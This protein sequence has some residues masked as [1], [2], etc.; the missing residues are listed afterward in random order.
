METAMS[1]RSFSSVHRGSPV[2]VG[3]IG[4]L[5]AG[6]AFA[7]GLADLTN[8]DAARGIKGALSA[9]ATSAVAPSPV[10]PSGHATMSPGSMSP[11]SMS[12]SPSMKMPRE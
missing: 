4:F 5:L 12:M 3:A 10:A 8:Q 9:G 11:G 7:L 1:H 2:L 6:S